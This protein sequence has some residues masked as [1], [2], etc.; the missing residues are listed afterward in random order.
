MFI[1]KTKELDRINPNINQ[2]YSAETIITPIYH[3]DLEKMKK[4]R[5]GS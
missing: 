5:S 3:T 4:S 2:E 1:T